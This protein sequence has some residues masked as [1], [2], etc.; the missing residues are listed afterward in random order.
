MFQGTVEIRTNWKTRHLF[1]NTN[2]AFCRICRLSK[3]KKKRE[4]GRKSSIRRDQFSTDWIQRKDHLDNL[5]FFSSMGRMGET[6][7]LNMRI[8]ARFYDFDCR[9]KGWRR[10][11]KGVKSDRAPRSVTPRGWHANEDRRFL[12]CLPEIVTKGSEPLI[13][14]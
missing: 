14:P 11:R 13:V 9:V 5:C 8:R 1:L 7:V 10:R 6:R 2:I 3:K 4:K 12:A